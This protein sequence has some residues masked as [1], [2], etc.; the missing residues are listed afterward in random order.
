MEARDT[1][2]YPIVHGTAPENGE[3]SRPSVAVVMVRNSRRASRSCSEAWKVRRVWLGQGG[4]GV[5]YAV[6]IS[7]RRAGQGKSKMRIP[8]T[9][10]GQGESAARGRGAA[11]GQKNMQ[12]LLLNA[13]F[14]YSTIAT[15]A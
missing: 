4:V 1:N 12:H 5:E 7:G 9:M 2:K 13:D 14:Q 15:A 11:V 8:S 10:T 3:F 6:G